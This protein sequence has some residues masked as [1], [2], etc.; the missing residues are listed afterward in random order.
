MELRDHKEKLNKKEWRVSHLYKITNKN[1]ELI[2]FKKNRAQ[3]HFEENRHTRNIILKSRQLGF[4]TDEAIDALDDTL[5]TKNFSTLMISYDQDSGVDL[6]DGKVKLAWDN[7]PSDIKKLFKVESNRANTL[8]FGFGNNTYS[9][10]RVRNKGRSGTYNRVHVSEF[11]KICK[12][13]PQKAK[14]IMSGTIPSI[15]LDG[16]MDIESTAEGESGHFYDMFWEAWDRGEPRYKQEFKSHFYNWTWDD[17][18]IAKV[19]KIIHI[20]DMDNSEIF[21]EYQT[22]HKLSD[23]EISFYYLKWLSMGKNWKLIQQEF[24]TTP[25]EAFI[26]SG[27][28]L[29]DKDVV[30]EMLNEA[31]DGVVED[32]WTTFEE[33]NPSHVYGIGAD[34][35]EGVG[36]D[37]SAITVWDFTPLKPKVVATYH[38]NTIDPDLFA[39]MIKAA[40]LKYGSCIVAPENNN[41]MGGACVLRLKDIYNEDLIFTTKRK[42]KVGEEKDTGKLGWSTN[43]ATKPKMF[44]D[45]KSAANDNVIDIPS[46]ILLHEMRTYDKEGLTTTRFDDE[47]TNHWDLLTSA[48]I[49]YQM[50]EYALESKRTYAGTQAGGVDPFYSGLV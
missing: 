35:A 23:I 4:T 26:S 30:A 39:H 9:N 10:F 17:D 40:G 19:E 3:A 21:E 16:R 8:K 1:T 42:E 47:A 2:T 50:K 6:F 29:F 32:S 7:V 33:Y 14:E 24:P 45:F 25:E 43:S 13:S 48:V 41:T 22:K 37:S 46:R 5:F 20:E 27:H 11:G 36:L 38:D 15:P 44:L 12:E 31:V 49:G 34:V 18:E 28:K